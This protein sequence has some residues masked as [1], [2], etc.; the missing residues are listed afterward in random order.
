LQLRTRSERLAELATFRHCQIEQNR[1]SFLL[2]RKNLKQI[3]K[4]LA[5][6]YDFCMVWQASVRKFLKPDKD[7]N[8]VMDATSSELQEMRHV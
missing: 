6:K 2:L 7:T 1:G 4:K 8:G 5:G 3:L